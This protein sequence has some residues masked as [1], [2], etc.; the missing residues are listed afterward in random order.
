MFQLN[1]V[2]LFK[3]NWWH[4]LK[5]VRKYNK[6]FPNR[7]CKPKLRFGRYGWM[8]M[9]PI[10]RDQTGKILDIY[11]FDLMWKDKWDEPRYEY[12]P[13][14]AITFF[15]KWQIGISFIIDTSDMPKHSWES[16]Q[17]YWWE[18]YLEKEYYDKTE[19]QY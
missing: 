14:I 10:S 9:F 19:R 3:I 12:S 7:K 15:R 6:R 4:P 13:F 1:I 2:N 11:G 18:T 5:D 16:T 17:D 8:F